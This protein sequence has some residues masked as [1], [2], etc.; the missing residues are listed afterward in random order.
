[1][2]DQKL[3]ALVIIL[4]TGFANLHSS[5]HVPY[6]P[7]DCIIMCCACL[8]ATSLAS[9]KLC[10]TRGRGVQCRSR[11]QTSQRFQLLS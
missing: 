11:I 5:V 2:F 8:C 7:V 3:A 9:V 6:I 1:M 10:S 4:Q